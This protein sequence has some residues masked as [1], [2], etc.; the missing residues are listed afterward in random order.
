MSFP[1]MPELHGFR[2]KNVGKVVGPIAS[3]SHL[4]QERAGDV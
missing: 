3:H 4:W 2:V 1:A